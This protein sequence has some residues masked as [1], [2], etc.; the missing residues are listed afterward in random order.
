MITGLLREW[1]KPYRFALN[2][3]VRVVGERWSRRSHEARDILERYGIPH[4]FYPVDA[5]EGRELLERVGQTAERLPVWVLNDG[6]A[7][8]DPS[9]EEFADAF[10]GRVPEDRQECEVIVIGGGPAGLAARASTPD[11]RDEPPR[12]VRGRRREAW[13]YQARCLRR[14]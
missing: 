1:T 6:R 7:L 2:A 4:A 3:V 13:I 11:P 8:V 12:R 5:S 14:R 10:V 9:N